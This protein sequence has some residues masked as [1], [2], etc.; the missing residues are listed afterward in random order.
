MAK[1]IHKYYGWHWVVLAV[2]GRKRKK[3]I[4]NSY[5]M[6]TIEEKL[7]LCKSTREVGGSVQESAI[8]MFAVKF[9]LA[10][11]QCL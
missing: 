7:L 9:F 1:E 8:W 6:Y 5:F 3:S 2:F 11:K 4:G 10:D